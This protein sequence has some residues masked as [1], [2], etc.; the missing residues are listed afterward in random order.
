MGKVDLKQFESADA[1]AQ[2]A[3]LQWLES[4]VLSQAQRHSAAFSGGRISEK[5]F[6]SISQQVQERSL[7]L[8]EV[9]FFWADERCVPPDHPDSNYRMMHLRLLQPLRIPDAQVHRIKGELGPA[10]A[11]RAASAEFATIVPPA[12][13][14]LFL[15]MGEDGHIASIFPAD[16]LDESPADYYRPISNAPKPPPGRV[17]LAMHA[18]ISARN[19]CVL[20]SGAAKEE[21]L[22]KS[23]KG[24][25][26][27]PLGRL[28]A[29]REFTR[30]FTNASPK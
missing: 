3:A 25:R 9:H 11:A 16:P 15:G 18:M 28:I 27:I 12:L 2:A 29:D 13:D 6:D 7:Q 22:G 5:F 26:E 24:H 10:P 23:L 1:L 8:P 21:A 20:V 19:V 4:L 30:V 14:S 17:T